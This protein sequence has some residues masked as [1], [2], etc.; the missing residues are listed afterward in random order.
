MARAG[1]SYD[2]VVAGAGMAGL[3]AAVLLS[4]RGFRVLLAETQTK[5]G[6]YL[7]DFHRGAWCFD[8]AANF[9]G[10]LEPGG[11]VAIL[12]E[13]V[14]LAGRVSFVPVQA[15]FRILLP[16]RQLDTRGGS[17]L[18]MLKAAFPESRAA[19]EQF[20]GV[21]RQIGGEIER[22]GR[23][24]PWQR[25]LLPL[26]CPRLFRHGRATVEPLAKQT[27]HDPVLRTL[28]TSFPATAPPDEVSLLFASAALH[29][30]ERGG[31]FYPAGGMGGLARALA[32]CAKSHGAE[33]LTGDGLEAVEHNG[34]RVRAVRLHSGERV[35]ARA[36][37]AAFNPADVLALLKGPGGAAV[38]A[39]RRRAASFRYA[40]S[41]FVIYLGLKSLP[42]TP[43]NFFF[44]TLYETI[45]LGSIY[46]TIARGE[47]PDSS[48]LHLVL[49]DAADAQYSAAAPVAKII[50][51]MPYAPFAR[52]REHAGKE[53]YR[54][55]KQEWTER[56]V[57]R[58]SSR[59]PSLRSR[60]KVVASATPLTL[61]HWTGNRGGAMYGLEATPSQMGPW[62]WPN[63]G[64][65]EGLYFCGHY[66][67]PAHGIVGACCS[68]RFAA[69]HA[70]S[71][72]K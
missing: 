16:D 9:L 28:L 13:E 15:N 37:I 71:D 18:E 21:L 8:A 66:T 48:V 4:A 38:E 44:T 32:D 30:S 6:G 55:M 45:D 41:A 72:L 64:V 63:R 34:R 14:G 27:V 25:A 68:G 62:R 43:D 54:R 33:I 11:E 69:N 22:F 56:L 3:T 50:T 7:A 36:V 61:E 59:I 31:L 52:C 20:A 51:P 57:E 46:R 65:L 49:P 1:G 35:A 60:I 40:A 23:L 26:F 42:E 70:A 24:R 12:L 2:A 39:A 10:G 5:V 19:I 29:K 53:A 17:Y 47:I 67:R 58:V